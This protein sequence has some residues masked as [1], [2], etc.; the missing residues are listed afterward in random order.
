MLIPNA[1]RAFMI[2]GLIIAGSNMLSIVS[3]Q[4]TKSSTSQAEP[5]DKFAGGQTADA[6]PVSPDEAAI[7]KSAAQFVAA[8]NRG[9]AAAVAAQW[10]EDGDYT[11]ELGQRYR[12]RAAIEAEYASFFKAY[13]GIKMEVAVDSVQVIN[14]T[15]AIEEGRARIEQMPAGVPAISRYTAVHVKQGNQWLMKS[16]R[17]SRIETASNLGRLADLQWLIGNWTAEHEGVDIK[18]TFAWRANKNCIERRFEVTKNGQTLSAGT[19]NIGWDPQQ[20]RIVSRLFD[21]QGGH[22]TGVW[23]PAEGGWTISSVSHTVDGVPSRSTDVMWRLDDGSLA[24]KSVNRVAADV[25]LADT[26][27]VVLKR[28]Q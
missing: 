1:T 27:A 7:R 26:E 22:A 5:Q 14:P 16:V 19:Q 2:I 11:N 15:T 6:K 23:F 18:Y 28:Q 12:G 10:T 3:A 9:D 17:D 4:E 24:W 25:A 21:H 13:P 20:Q 8:F